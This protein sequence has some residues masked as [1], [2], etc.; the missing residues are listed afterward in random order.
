MNGSQWLPRIFFASLP[1][2]N[3]SK[4]EL[5]ELEMSLHGFETIVGYYAK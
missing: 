4:A 2:I 5:R 1:M 3:K